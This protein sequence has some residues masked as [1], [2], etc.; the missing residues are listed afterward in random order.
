MHVWV[1]S[2]TTLPSHQAACPA[3]HGQLLHLSPLSKQEGMACHL[4]MLAQHSPATS[5]LSLMYGTMFL[6]SLFLIPFILLFR[7]H[8]QP[9]R[10]RNVNYSMQIIRTAN[11]RLGTWLGL[12]KSIHMLI[13]LILI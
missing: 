1:N 5:C 13:G 8:S 2:Q 3:Q 12:L 7:Q 4:A 11:L 10:K 9:N 6:S